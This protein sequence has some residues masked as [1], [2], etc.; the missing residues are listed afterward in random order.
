MSRMTDR[1]N[2]AIR[3]HLAPLGF[4]LIGPCRWAGPSKAHLRQ[5][6]EFYAIRQ[7]EYRGQWGFS[8]DFVPYFPWVPWGPLFPKP[9]FRWKYKTRHAAFDLRIRAVDLGMSDCTVGMN[10]LDFSE[11]SDEEI[12]SVVATTVDVAQLDFARITS[13][14]DVVAAFHERS[15]A[16]TRGLPFDWHHQTH[17]AWGLGHM[18]LG[19]TE[20]GEAR[21]QKF[22]RTYR[23]DPDHRFLQK[24]RAEAM[25]L[26]ADGALI[27]DGGALRS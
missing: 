5:M 20:E 15:Q 11:S 2:H 18:A 9:N 21:L 1:I 12:A 25:R 3:P 24:A 7:D 23:I 26:F 17:L 6:F 13:V 4:E 27:A 16:P 14:A 10:W 8:L 22:C 19:D